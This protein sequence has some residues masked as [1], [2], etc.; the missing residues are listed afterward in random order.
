MDG[1]VAT[2]STMTAVVQPSL[3]RV[4]LAVQPNWTGSQ[5]ALDFE[6]LP[7]NLPRSNKN[8]V[9]LWQGSTVPW[10]QMPPPFGAPV[11][12][13]QEA[14]SIVLSGLTITNLAYTVGYAV[15]PNPGDFCASSTFHPDGTRSCRAPQLAINFIGSTSLGLHY[16]VLPGCVPATYKSWVGLWKGEIQP[17]AAPK[18]MATTQV[19]SSAS[20]DDVAFNDVQLGIRT[21]YTAVYFMGP[22][23]T[24]GAA[25]L[26]FTTSP[27]LTVPESLPTKERVR[28]TFK[29]ATPRTT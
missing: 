4:R 10:N 16:T 6:T 13:D 24:S 15:G 7:G 1:P 14:G 12:V 21:Q 5:L 23:Y 2:R 19:T 3:S 17:Y 9:G 11:S 29:S 26:T 28:W 18:P 22:E 20:E 27:A 8:R 25:Q